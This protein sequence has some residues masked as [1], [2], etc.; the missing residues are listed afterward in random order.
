MRITSHW[1][2]GFN[3]GRKVIHSNGLDPRVTQGVANEAVA[4]KKA[5]LLESHPGRDNFAKR[6]SRNARPGFPLSTF[7]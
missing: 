4:L 6:E 5:G 1:M 7:L 3:L 2:V